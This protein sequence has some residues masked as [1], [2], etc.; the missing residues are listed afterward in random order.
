MKRNVNDD[1]KQTGEFLWILCS[2]ESYDRTSFVQN[3]KSWM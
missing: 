1:M 2:A 3:R